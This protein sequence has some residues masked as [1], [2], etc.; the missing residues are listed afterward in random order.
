MTHTQT[1]TAIF[2]KI[3]EVI[4]VFPTIP[5]FD[6]SYWKG[7]CNCWEDFHSYGKNDLW[8][9]VKIMVIEYCNKLRNGKPTAGL[10]SVK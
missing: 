10:A 3:K 5:T 1:Q 2:L 6:F 9:P 7:Y 8:Q 4:D